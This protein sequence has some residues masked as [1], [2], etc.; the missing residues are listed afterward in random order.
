MDI[1]FFFLR[2][3]ALLVI[4]ILFLLYQ[5][6]L[7]DQI[8]SRYFVNL[9]CGASINLPAVVALRCYFVAK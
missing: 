9:N 5:H 7:G 3:K 4:T 6:F 1:G 2:V 8:S